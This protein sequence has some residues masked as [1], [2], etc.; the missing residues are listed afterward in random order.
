MG[1]V[2]IGLANNGVAYSYS[3]TPG[4]YNQRQY[5]GMNEE[6]VF[7]TDTRDLVIE[8]NGT[9]G[10]L[11]LAEGTYSIECFGVDGASI[12]FSVKYG[13]TEFYDLEDPVTENKGFTIAG[14]RLVM[15]T[16]T[17]YSSPITIIAREICNG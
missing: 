10:P 11:E 8:A 9:Y 1:T 3:G 4:V 15:A 7:A 14:N 13:D 16:V 5:H 2:V 17:N 6:I 12:Q